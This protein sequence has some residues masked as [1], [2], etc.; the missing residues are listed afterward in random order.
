MQINVNTNTTT[1]NQSVESDIS[2]FTLRFLVVMLHL[3]FLFPSNYYHFLI[4]L[5]SLK[6]A[7]ISL[8]N[9]KKQKRT[10]IPSHHHL[11]LAARTQPTQ[12]TSFLVQRMNLH[13]LKSGNL[14]NRSHSFPPMEHNTIAILLLPSLILYSLLDQYQQQT[15]ILLF[16]PYKKAKTRA[17]DVVRMQFWHAGDPEF[18][19]QGGGLRIKRMVE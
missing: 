16:C 15:K 12:A 8:R 11:Y 3:P 14:S 2:P 6:S 9:M 7:L 1:R 5:H 13:F 4:N 17:R 18:N 19:P 10:S